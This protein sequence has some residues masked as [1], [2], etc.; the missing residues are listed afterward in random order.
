MTLGDSGIDLGTR[1]DVSLDKPTI[2]E[3]EHK[4]KE[5]ELAGDMIKPLNLAIIDTC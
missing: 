2:Q 1:S 4:T 3:K 5:N